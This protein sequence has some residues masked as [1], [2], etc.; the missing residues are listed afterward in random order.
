MF[1]KRDIYFFTLLLSY[2]T[3][4]EK[5]NFELTKYNIT[6]DGVENIA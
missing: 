2:F 5:I 4:K 3:Q 1:Y 6:I